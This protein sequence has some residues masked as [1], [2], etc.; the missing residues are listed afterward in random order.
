MNQVTTQNK[1]SNGLEILG[2]RINSLTEAMQLADFFAKSDL[3]PKDYKGKAGNIVVA[4]QKGHEVGLL[5]Q[6]SLE[7][8]AVINGRACIWGDGLIALVKSNPK[9][10]WTNEWIEG[11]GENAVAYCETKRKGQPKTIKGSFSAEQAKVAGLWG[12][13]TWK[14]YPERMLQMRARGFCFRDAYPDVLNGIELAEEQLDAKNSVQNIDEYE[15]A[16]KQLGLK[17]TKKDGLATVEGNAFQHSKALKE[18]GFELIDN[19]WSIYYEDVIDAQ[20]VKPIQQQ[21]ETPKSIPATPSPAK[22]LAIFL[23][24]N[25]LSKEEV[26]VFVKEHLRLSNQ[27]TEKIQAELLNKD[28]LLMKVQQFINPI[29]EIQSDDIDIDDVF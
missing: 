23:M 3:V 25:G 4:W 21:T 27:D 24:G 22:E 6:Q 5:P 16:V 8:I 7:T 12:V 14:K 13:N 19:K 26:G 17:L 11:A 28:E 29:P 9:E 2:M 20:V 10:E 15:N 1:S 18:L